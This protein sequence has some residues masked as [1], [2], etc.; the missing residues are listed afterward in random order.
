MSQHNTDDLLPTE[1]IDTLCTILT[2][3]TDKPAEHWRRVIMQAVGDTG[4][5]KAASVLLH[6]SYPQIA[7]LLHTLRRDHVATLLWLVG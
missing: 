4:S 6:L 1:H 5:I 7:E 2:Q 3:L